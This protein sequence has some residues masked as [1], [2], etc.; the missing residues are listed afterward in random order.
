MKKIVLTGGGTAG[1]V[2]PNIAMLPRLRELGYEIYYIGSYDG[3]EK[4]L[5]EACGIPYY[6]IA[7]G[8]FRRYFDTKNFSD[9]FRVLKGISEARH[10]LTKL[11]PDI[12]FSKGGFVGVPVV[13]AA[14]SRHI[15]VIC[16]ESDMTPGLANRLSIPLATKVCCN[17]PETIAH[18][19]EDKAVLTG[20]PI[21]PELLQGSREKGLAF[22]GL[23]GDKPVILIIGGSLGAQA[24]NDAVHASLDKL[25]AKFDIIHL[26]GK[27]KLDE[28]YLDVPGYKQFEYLSAEL[29]D[30]L[31]ATDIVLSR[32]GANAVFEFLAL[33]K[34]AVLVPLPLSASRGDQIL[35]AKYFARKGYAAMLEQETLTPE[36]LVEALDKI[37]EERLAYI[38]RMSSDP[39]AD[40][41][42][43][44]LA[45]IREAA[46]KA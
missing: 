44:V 22:T 13:R 2:T 14:K 24:V 1:H 36:S 6:G 5:I 23:T 41:T 33:A 27:G 9:P 11:D 18:L 30:A 8:K 34:P 17:F 10:L 19:P 21:R 3:I 7:T 35:N 28:K 26:C 4:E 46:K 37:Y 29:P 38:S 40:G 25:T 12:V 32:A 20:T 15:P 45:V 42:D 39:L 43:E 16:H 31:A